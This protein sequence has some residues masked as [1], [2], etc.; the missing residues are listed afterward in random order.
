[1]DA[2]INCT[3]DDLLGIDQIGPKITTS[4]LEITQNPEFKQL[5]STLLSLGIEPKLPTSIQTGPLSSKTCLITGTLSQPR[6]K[7][8]ALIKQHGGK[9]VKSV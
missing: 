4:L 5:V 7:I 9:V 3:E 6:S 8:E 1:M 2:L